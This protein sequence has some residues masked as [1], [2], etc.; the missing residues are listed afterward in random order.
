MRTGPFVVRRQR[1][2]ILIVSL[3]ML[4]LMTLLA[5]SMF[6]SYGLADK[7][8]GNTRDKQH[9]FQAAQS[10]LRFG[11]IWLAQPGNAN[12]GVACAAGVITLQICTQGQPT[13]VLTA[14]AWVPN[15]A[16]GWAGLGTPYQP[17]AVTSSVIGGSISPINVVAGGA[18]ATANPEFD[19][20]S[21]PYVYINYL[22]PGPDGQSKIYQ[23]S[24]AAQ[25]ATPSAVAVVQSTF[26]VVS[27]IKNPGGP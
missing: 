8:A 11:E 6:R 10:A 15:A 25:G 21:Q 23:V 17:A 5:I 7:I 16:T 18:A 13:S 4:L 19:Y 22:G 24:A 2:V 26:S 12:L 20:F 9:A 1:G 14:Q 3:V 27:A